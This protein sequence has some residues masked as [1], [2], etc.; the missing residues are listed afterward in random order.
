MHLLQSPGAGRAPA[1]PQQLGLYICPLI[2]FHLRELH[3]FE[4]QGFEQKP[5]PTTTWHSTQGTRARAKAV[6]DMYPT[7]PQAD[8][9]PTEECELWIKEVELLHP[10]PLECDGPKIEGAPECGGH[11][12]HTNQANLPKSS[13]LSMACI[14]GSNDKCV[15]I[16]TPERI[17]ILYKAYHTAKTNG[18][19]ADILPALKLRWSPCSSDSPTASSMA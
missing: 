7:N 15:G 5:N 3:D 2:V 17:P 9:Q 6:F 14:L 1:W 19:H 8:I 12:S 18:G 16:L 10:Q 11:I 13:M 4:R